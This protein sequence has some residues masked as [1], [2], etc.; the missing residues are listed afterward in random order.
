MAPGSRAA[1]RSNGQFGVASVVAMATGAALLLSD[2]P[3]RYDRRSFA[4]V[5][6]KVYHGLD[7]TERKTRKVV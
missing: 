1:A 2:L 5:S 3:Q 7:G 4:V 6:T